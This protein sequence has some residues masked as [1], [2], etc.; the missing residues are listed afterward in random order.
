MQVKPSSILQS[1]EQPSPLTALPSSHA[2]VPSKRPSPHFVVQP[3]PVGGQVGS[4]I[5]LAVHP[6]PRSLFLVAGSQPSEPSTTPLPH[7]VA[8][9]PAVVHT[10]PGFTEQSALQA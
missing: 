10:Q 6:S 7:T 1:E 4:A 2:S 3:P 8:W 9:Q 5:Q